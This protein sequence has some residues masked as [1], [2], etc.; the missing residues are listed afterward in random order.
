ME[1]TI[2]GIIYL[3]MVKQFL[4]TQLDEDDQ[5]GLLYYQAKDIQMS[6][7]ALHIYVGLDIQANCM[8]SSLTRL[9]TCQ[10]WV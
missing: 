10:F 3:D 7:N 9:D 5:N 1:K 8:A 6:W 2:N 4:I